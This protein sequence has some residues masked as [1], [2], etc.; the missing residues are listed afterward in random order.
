MDDQQGN[1]EKIYECAYAFGFILG[2][3]SLFVT[4]DGKYVL[5]F[6]CADKECVHRTMLQILN[7]FPEKNPNVST[8]TVNLEQTCI[9]FNGVETWLFFAGP[10]EYKQIIPQ[11]F[12]SAPLEVKQELIAGLMDSDGCIEYFKQNGYEKFK[13]VFSNNKLELVKGL[14]GL[15]RTMGVE[16]GQIKTSIEYTGKPQYRLTPNIYSFAHR[17]YFRCE[18]KQ[19]R[20]ERFKKLRCASETTN[21][22]PT[23]G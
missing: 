23:S 12:F 5:S 6:G 1:I 2:D 19:E 11:C 7:V 17:C 16:A 4:G 18:R 9:R 14:A 22:A 10:T 3:G 13:V 20:L 15:W 8:K 21:T